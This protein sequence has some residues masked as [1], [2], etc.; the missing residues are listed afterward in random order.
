MTG[1]ARNLRIPRNNSN[2]EILDDSHSLYSPF[3]NSHS[4][5]PASRAAVILV[6][7]SVYGMMDIHLKIS[8]LLDSSTVL[9][10][11]YIS[12]KSSGFLTF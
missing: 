7:C 6:W 10:D 8:D 5:V 1:G 11:E 2:F 3:W 4:P 12:V 9:A